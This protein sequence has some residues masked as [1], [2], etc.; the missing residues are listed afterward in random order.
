MCLF[1]FDFQLG[2]FRFQFANV[3]VCCFVFLGLVNLSANQFDLLLNCGHD[4]TLQSERRAA[5]SSMLLP[6][7]P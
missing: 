1:F 6:P 2:D 3:S 5:H 4:K 7:P